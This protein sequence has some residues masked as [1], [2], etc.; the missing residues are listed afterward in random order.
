MTNVWVTRLFRL[1]SD[2]VFPG[3]TANDTL[4]TLAIVA[5][6]EWHIANESE[7]AVIR[8]FLSE[9]SN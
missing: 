8:Q 9:N 1:A 5:L 2:L 6:V 7:R 3:V 4:F